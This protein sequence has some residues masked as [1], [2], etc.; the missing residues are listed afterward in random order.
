MISYVMPMYLEDRFIGVVG[1]DF[2]FEYM[3]NRVHQIKIYEN[4]Y[5]HLEVNGQKINPGE[6]ESEEQ[7]ASDKYLRVSEEL[8]NG[9]TIVLS[10]S[11]DDLRQI[12]YEIAFKILFVVLAL[13]ALFTIIVILLVKR[14]VVPLIKLAEASKSLSKGNYNVEITHSNTYELK[15]LSTAFENMIVNLR[16]HEKLQ[17]ILAYRDSLTGLRNTTSYKAWMDD[18]NKVIQ[19]QSPKFGV[20]VFD[21]NYLKEA[22]DRY[23]HDAGNKLIVAV[24]RMIADTFKRSPVFRIGGDEFLVILQNRDLDDRE[25]LFEKIAAACEEHII[26]SGSDS[27]TLSVAM[28][29]SEYDPE[30]DKEF[31]DVFNRADDAMYQNKREMKNRLFVNSWGGKKIKN[32]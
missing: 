2:D 15:L 27:I 25:R 31:V 19:T 11:Y 26:E 28:G 14:M 23:G 6:S 1:M 8:T 9:M 10:A 5:A 12:R 13:V 3:A 20:V 21:I 4:G 30:T 32:N 29:F 17:H 16:E 7:E 18:F 24:A 22:N